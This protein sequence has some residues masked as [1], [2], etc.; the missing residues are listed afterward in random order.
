VTSAPP[1]TDPNTAGR[2]RLASSAEVGRT[3]LMRR[4]GGG[5]RSWTAL[6]W[7]T[8]SGALVAMDALCPHQRYPMDD[9][10]LVGDSVEC[11]YHGFRFGPTGRCLNMRRARPARILDVWEADGSIWLAP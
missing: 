7:R 10:R 2:W 8:R 6:L 5:D 1:T 9:A 4:V 11:P 3:P